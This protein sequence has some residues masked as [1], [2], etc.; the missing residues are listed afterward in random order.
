MCF[1]EN[2]IKKGGKNAYF[3]TDTK[4]QGNVLSDGGSCS[5]GPW[6]VTFLLSKLF[7]FLS[8]CNNMSDNGS[9]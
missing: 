5:I 6:F 1:E 9:L 7:P 8:F 4:F 3:V 2:K